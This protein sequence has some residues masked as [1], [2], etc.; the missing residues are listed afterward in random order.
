MGPSF[1]WRETISKRTNLKVLRT[2]KCA[3]KEITR[4]NIRTCSKEFKIF[5]A[6][7]F[8]LNFSRCFPQHLTFLFYLK[9]YPNNFTSHGKCSKIWDRR[10]D[11]Y[12]YIFKTHP[13]A[14]LWVGCGWSPRCVYVPPLTLQ[15]PPPPTPP[16]KAAS[17]PFHNWGQLR[18][19]GSLQLKLHYCVRAD[20]P[21]CL[22][23]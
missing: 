13:W 22:A 15:G 3:M 1:Q 17:F 2:G 6:F 16:E 18:G 10:N 12:L 14:A 8:Y 21:S 7:L 20:Y 19:L 4:D 5:S 23:M 11:F 9:N